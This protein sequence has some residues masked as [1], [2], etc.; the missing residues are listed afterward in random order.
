MTRRSYLLTAIAALSILVAGCGD[1]AA[2]EDDH[3]HNS[4]LKGPNKGDLVKVTDDVWFE[5][6]IIHDEKAMIV[7][8]HTGPHAGNLQPT[9]AQYQPVLL[10]TYEDGEARVEG[11]PYPTGGENAFKI[12]HPGLQWDIPDGE[13]S[14]QIGDQ[15]KT[16]PLPEHHH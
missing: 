6:V 2:P 5:V 7:W 8:T 9:K 12:V 4:S 14:T 3:Q 15:V 16:V 10:F 1:E 11:A 13:L